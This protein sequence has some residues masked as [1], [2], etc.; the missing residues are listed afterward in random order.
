MPVLSGVENVVKWDFKN[1]IGGKKMAK[2]KTNAKWVIQNKATGKYLQVTKWWGVDRWLKNPKIATK[3]PTKS[4]AQQEV[5][6]SEKVV[7]I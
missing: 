3:W 7:K 6:E 2:T 4:R 5:F 1:F